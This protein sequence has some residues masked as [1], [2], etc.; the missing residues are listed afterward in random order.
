[1]PPIAVA[2]Y[3]SQTTLDPAILNGVQ[4]NAMTEFTVVKKGEE[5]QFDSAFS[6][7]EIAKYYLTENMSFS[8]FAMDLVEKNKLSEKQIAWVH[9]L[10]TEHLNKELH[11]E[12]L[13]AE[14]KD[15]VEKMYAKVKANSRKFQVRLPGGFTISTVTKGVN[16]GAV[17]IFEGGEYL[18]KITKE[19]V[20]ELKV[21]NEEVKAL[22]EDANENLLRL[23]QLY[24]H[25]S[26]NCSVCGRTLNDP[27]SVQMGIGPVCAKRFS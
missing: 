24:G 15:V 25:E 11:K 5:I 19:G 26:G 12:T 10:A 13:P 27:L 21:P 4:Q 6:S 3:T 18:G 17:Y 7:L 9:F 14:F 1:M 2:H 22:L 16:V 20:L 8:N 23:A